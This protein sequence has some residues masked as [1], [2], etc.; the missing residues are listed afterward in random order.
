MYRFEADPP[1]GSAYMPAA[2]DEYVQ[3]PEQVIELKVTP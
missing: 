3:P 1:P 2:I